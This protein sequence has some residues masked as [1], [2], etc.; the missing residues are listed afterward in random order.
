MRIEPDIYLVGSG[1]FGFD[2]TDAY[3]CNIFLLDAGDTHILFD[4]GAGMGTDAILEICQQD[5]L[6][7]SRI[8]HLFLTHAHTDHGGG[9]AHLRDRLDLEIYAGQRTAEIVSAGDEDAVSLTPAK[10]GGIYPADYVYRATPVE[11]GLNDG[12]A[13]EIG[14]FKIELIF[15]PGHSHDHCSYLV[16]GPNKRYLVSGDAIFFGGQVVLQNT[17]DCSV[18]KTIASIQR[19]GTIDFDALLPGHHVFSLQNGKR[20]IDSALEVIS[21]FGCPTSIL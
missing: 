16:T 1:A 19:L 7:L 21:R 4:A 6:D 10:A 18:P 2:M 15:T 13:L 17:Y 5:G 8:N 12:D 20:H 9:T 14:K 3:D 11:H